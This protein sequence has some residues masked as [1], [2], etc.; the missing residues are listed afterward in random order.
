M[1]VLRRFAMVCVEPAAECVDF[2]LVAPARDFARNRRAVDAGDQC[3]FG[4]CYW[5]GPCLD[6]EGDAADLATLAKHSPPKAIE[7]ADAQSGGLGSP[8]GHASARGFSKLAACS[9][10]ISL[11]IAR[12]S[13]AASTISPAFAPVQPS[14]LAI[15]SRTGRSPLAYSSSWNCAASYHHGEVFRRRTLPP[16]MTAICAQ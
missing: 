10:L 16:I 12:P 5:L 14:R 2:A 6:Q 4:A 11:Q 3:W 13:P 9:R 7:R 1:L 8:G 15:S